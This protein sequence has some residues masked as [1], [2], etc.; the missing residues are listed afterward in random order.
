MNVMS[1]A[2]IDSN[3]I[4]DYFSSVGCVSLENG[5]FMLILRSIYDAIRVIAVDENLQIIDKADLNFKGACFSASLHAVQ[6]NGALIHVAKTEIVSSS[7][8]KTYYQGYSSFWY[9][10]SYKNGKIDVKE[11]RYVPNANLFQVL[12]RVYGE[13]SIWIC[14]K[15]VPNQD[16][17]GEY[18]SG[19]KQMIGFA[20]ADGI[21]SFQF[22]PTS[23]K[24][25][26]AGFDF[27]LRKDMIHLFAATHFSKTLS[28]ITIDI[29]ELQI[30]ESDYSPKFGRK[31]DQVGAIRLK[32][33]EPALLFWN[34]DN[35]ESNKTDRSI[36]Y[37]VV[38]VD[39][40]SLVQQRFIQ[41]K[42]LSRFTIG[43]NADEIFTLATCCGQPEDSL[44]V[45]KM[46]KQDGKIESAN[47]TSDKVP[48]TV[49]DPV[50]KV[51]LA[52]SFGEPTMI[53]KIRG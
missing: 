42:E 21:P 26:D 35:Q 17:S 9:T 45:T 37:S 32:G 4:P 30:Q 25:I 2:E 44:H 49:L 52:I 24:T 23:Y 39:D 29:A 28:H 50:D 14:L 11:V 33:E 27:L 8:G 1:L 51:F 19:S 5:G 7:T 3:L 16:E 20:V 10:V 53:Y 18:K 46:N 15:T 6:V 13:S 48:I 40:F 41:T 38:N 31:Y 34:T 47:K 43:E 22:L 36:F 12:S